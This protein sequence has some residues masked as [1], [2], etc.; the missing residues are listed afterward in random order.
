[1]TCRYPND[2]RKKPD[3]RAKVCR[4]CALAIVKSQPEQVEAIQQ[5]HRAYLE[6]KFAWLP[7]DRRAEYER[8]KVLKFKAH[9]ARQIILQDMRA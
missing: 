9:E 3:P 4:G 2:C 8:L 1:M 7:E 6:R 5:R